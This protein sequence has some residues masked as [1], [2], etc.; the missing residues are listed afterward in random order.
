VSP[1]A[2]DRALLDE[3]VDLARAAGAST[4]R[5]FRSTGL[6]IDQKGDGSPV[7]EADRAAERLVREHLARAHPDDAVVGEE[8]AP[9][10]GTSGRC[11]IVDPIDGTKA[12]TH[13]VPLY[14]TLLAVDDEH[15]PAVGV[16]DLPALGE[17]VYAGRGLGCFCN[18]EPVGVSAK[19]EL[20]GAYLTTSGY[21]FWPNDVLLAAKAEGMLLRTWG[22]GYGYALVATG[23]V[24]AMV[25]FGVARYDVAAMPVILA[26]AGGR[27]TDFAGEPRTDAGTGL[28][29]NGHLHEPLRELL[30]ANSRQ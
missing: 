16:I 19:A 15:G 26:E 4:T 3:A 28:A 24:E 10:A 27:F 29:T 25:D 7:T 30:T 20:A 21:D 13:G 6:V 12:F 1:P 11:W 8:E 18:G 14:S 9:T 2:A 23:R 17:T 22:D 5:W